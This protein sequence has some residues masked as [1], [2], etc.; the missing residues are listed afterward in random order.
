M[1]VS[2]EDFRLC[3]DA[4]NEPTT[5][6]QWSADSVLAVDAKNTAIDS[7]RIRHKAL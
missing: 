6:Y 7:P 5:V 4:I 3:V 2:R 1:R